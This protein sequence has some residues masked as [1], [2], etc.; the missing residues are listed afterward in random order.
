MLDS[1]TSAPLDWRLDYSRAV[2]GY[3][4][5]YAR[6]VHQIDGQLA[7]F[8]RGDSTLVVGAWDVRGDSTLVGRK[9]DAALVLAAPDDVVRIS[10]AAEQSAIGRIATTAL[11]DT[12]WI[13]LELLATKERRAGRL[14]VGLPKRPTGRVALSDLLLYTPSDRVVENL[15]AARDSALGSSVVPFDRNLGV[16]YEAYGLAPQ[17]EH[18]RFTLTFEQIDIG[19]RQRAAE[20]LK[21]SDP[22]TAVHIEWEEMARVVDGINGHGQRVDLS[23]LR[24]GKYRVTL[25]VKADDG[26]TATTSREVVVRDR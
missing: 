25:L 13:S 16:F 26:S 20:R 14:R 15:T 5:S 1:G 2:S 9:L 8:R 17:G 24:S 6:S 23:K 10:R 3:A 4:P 11:I 18:L 22:S 19:W 21:L 7:S 12:G